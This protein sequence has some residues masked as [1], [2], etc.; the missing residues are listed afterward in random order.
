M[1]DDLELLTLPTSGCW[2]CSFHFPDPLSLAICPSTLL[3]SRPRVEEREYRLINHGTVWSIYLECIQKGLQTKLTLRSLSAS[4]CWRSSLVP[5][6]R[7]VPKNEAPTRNTIYSDT[8][9]E[10]IGLERWL[11]QRIGVQL[12]APTWWL[13]TIHNSSFRAYDTLFW[14]SRTPDTY[15]VHINRL[16]QNTHL[17]NSHNNK[18]FDSAPTYLPV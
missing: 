13:T 14:P 18:D 17:E 5:I 2:P 6:K 7:S 9:M 12:Q 11:F 16:R 15:V 10:T 4:K 3:L 1:E 8:K